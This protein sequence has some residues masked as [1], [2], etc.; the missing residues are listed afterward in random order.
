[1]GMVKMTKDNKDWEF[2]KSTL[3]ITVGIVGTACLMVRIIGNILGGG[4]ML[5]ALPIIGGLLLTSIGGFR[6][7]SRHSENS[8]KP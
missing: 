1:M 2:I 8:P 6:L 3:D 7:F 4:M 5:G